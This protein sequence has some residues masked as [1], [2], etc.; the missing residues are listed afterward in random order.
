VTGPACGRCRQT[1]ELDADV[2]KVVAEVK[3]MTAPEASMPQPLHS[4]WEGH[5]DQPAWDGYAVKP[6]WS[7]YKTHELPQTHKPVPATPEDFT[8]SNPRPSQPMGPGWPDAA[9]SETADFDKRLNACLEKVDQHVRAG[10]EREDRRRQTTRYCKYCGRQQFA[11]ECI[12]QARREPDGFSYVEGDI[13]S[14]GSYY[15]PEWV[16]YPC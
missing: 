9:D 11:A 16:S 3:K 13:N 14:G 8:K 2:T 12:C 1:D 7:E 10:K 6:D 15:A 4:N 5:A